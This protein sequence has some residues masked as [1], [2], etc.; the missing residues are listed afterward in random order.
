[1]MGK[2]KP[3]ER[4]GT[5]VGSEMSGHSALKSESSSQTGGS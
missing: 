2:K 1:M 3:L 5:G 4:T